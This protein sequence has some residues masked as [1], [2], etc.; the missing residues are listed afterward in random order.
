MREP[1]PLASVHEAVLE[2][3]RDRPDAVLYGAQ[4]V[5]AYVDERRMTQVVDLM[6]LRARELAE[7][8]RLHLADR[9]TIAV[10][11][12]AVRDGIGYRVY[13]L[14]QPRNR[15]LV[16]VRSVTVLPPSRAIGGLQVLAPSDLVA[17]KV[18]SMA[19]RAKS[20]KGATDLADL[21]RL[22]LAF[23]SFKTVDGEVHDRLR[24]NGAGAAALSAWRDLVAQDIQPADDDTF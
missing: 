1:L 22:L 2:F 8:I 14:L 16:D 6:S 18:I 12:R 21:R 23:P 5:N 4:A 3:L 11:V 7:E 24:A 17:A 9:F 15:H 13:Q 10:R 20:A 19:E